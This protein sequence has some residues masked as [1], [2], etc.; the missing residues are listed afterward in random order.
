[1]WYIIIIIWFS[2]LVLIFGRIYWI[3]R[4]ELVIF[5]RPKISHDI[6]IELSKRPD[7]IWPDL[8]SVLLETK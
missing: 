5:K 6:L 1:M 3:N 8:D 2:S 4:K 7:K